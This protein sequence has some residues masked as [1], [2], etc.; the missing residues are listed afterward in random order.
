MM[1]PIHC[2]TGGLWQEK[3]KCITQT[4]F[5]HILL[6]AY[7]F[8]MSANTPTFLEQTNAHTHTHVSVLMSKC[9]TW[10]FLNL[11]IHPF[12]DIHTCIQ[13]HTAAVCCTQKHTHLPY[14]CYTYTCQTFQRALAIYW[15]LL[16]WF[17]RWSSI[18]CH[19][20]NCHQF[21]VICAALINLMWPAM[22]QK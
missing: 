1:I 12:K 21:D 22:I 6:Q 16:R 7:K 5:Y 17:V 19:L 2:I 13:I 20:G 8:V 18:W 14:L 15:Q 4:T 9:I 3:V 11:Q 10:Y